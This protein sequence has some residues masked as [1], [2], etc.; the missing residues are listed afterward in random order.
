MSVFKAKKQEEERLE[1]LRKRKEIKKSKQKNLEKFVP[2]K[3]PADNNNHNAQ[4]IVTKSDKIDAF[5]LE[6]N[7]SDDLT[8]DMT[9]TSETR[10]DVNEGLDDDTNERG[11][12]LPEPMSKEEIKEFQR[13]LFERLDLQLKEKGII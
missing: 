13:K 7:N 6:N 3:E 2:H 9:T 11:P 8:E 4:G 12:K 10:E 1:K 5:K